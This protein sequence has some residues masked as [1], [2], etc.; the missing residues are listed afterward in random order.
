[1]GRRNLDGE[2][3]DTSRVPSG[4]RED[5][6]RDVVAGALVVAVAAVEVEE[7]DLL[8][9]AGEQHVVGVVHAPGA[10]P[11]GAGLVAERRRLWA[12]EV[13][14]VDADAEIGAA[15]PL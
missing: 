2:R 4:R 6:H 3:Q 13:A 1:M 8:A 11:A 15:L 7:L 14:L 12:E 5:L 10:P 9:G